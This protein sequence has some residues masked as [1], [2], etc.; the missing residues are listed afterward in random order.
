[1]ALVLWAVELPALGLRTEVRAQAIDMVGSGAELTAVQLAA[2][3]AHLAVGL[4]LDDSFLLALGLGQAWVLSCH[5][6][7][8]LPIS[9]VH[10]FLRYSKAILH[11]CGVLADS[12]SGVVK[13]FLFN[14]S[15]CDISFR[16]LLALKDRGLDA[17]HFGQ[18]LSLL[19]LVELCIFH[20]V[21]L[22]GNVGRLIFAFCHGCL[23]VPRHN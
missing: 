20:N 23:P 22:D 17:L 21:F 5:G 14:V 11:D 13:V 9:T 18:P 4:W 15:V 10:R 12:T 19:I 16:K 2:I 7:D 1:M 3:H 8:G 6:W